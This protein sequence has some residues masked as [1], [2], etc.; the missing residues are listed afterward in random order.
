MPGVGAD[1]TEGARLRGSGPAWAGPSRDVWLS[2]PPLAPPP[3]LRAQ[4]AL[5]R[6]TRA[7]V[8][9]RR[10]A[11]TSAGRGRSAKA[12]QAG[13]E[14]ARPGDGEGRGGSEGNPGVRGVGQAGG[15][16]PPWEGAGRPR[17]RLPEGNSAG[18]QPWEFSA[19]AAVLSTYGTQAV[20]VRFP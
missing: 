1:R 19:S 16:G 2:A 13:R 7:Q 15:A 12:R 3:Q 18:T 6:E 5:L 9:P 14:G 17:P 4:G 20:G 11:A 10:S 8:R